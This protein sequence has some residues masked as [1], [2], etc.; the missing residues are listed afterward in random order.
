VLDDVL[1]ISA[2]A[3]EKPGRH[4]IKEG[5]PDEVQ[6]GLVTDDSPNMDWLV[7]FLLRTEDRKVDP[8]EVWPEASAPNDVFHTKDLFVLE[9]RKSVSRADHPAHALNASI[10][11]IRRP[12]THEWG[13]M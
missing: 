6:S 10:G 12:D 3:R 2:D 7:R 5:K 13:S 1:R 8:R 11:Y 9:E 4:R